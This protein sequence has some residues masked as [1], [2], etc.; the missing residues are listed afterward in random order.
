[1]GEDHVDPPYDENQ[2]VASPYDTP[3][4][5]NDSLEPYSAYLLAAVPI[6]KPP[7]KVATSFE[8]AALIIMAL[9]FHH[10][11]NKP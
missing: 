6:A 2:G 11:H 5:F 4:Y 7:F 10:P 8:I 3:V 9:T 1:M